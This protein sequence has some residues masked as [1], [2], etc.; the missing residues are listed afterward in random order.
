ML[1]FSHT[2]FFVHI[3]KFAMIHLV[4]GTPESRV[5]WPDEQ[6]AMMQYSLTILLN[7]EPIL[8]HR[9]CRPTK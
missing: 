9:H 8:A 5:T 6:T 3:N 4:F 7:F 1:L 2:L